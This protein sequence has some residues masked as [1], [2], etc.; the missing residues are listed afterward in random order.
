MDCVSL[1]EETNEVEQ[2]ETTEK[3]ATTDQ[4]KQEK[5]VK[6]RK[7]NQF[8]KAFLRRERV[9]ALYSAGFK[10]ARIHEILK[11][12]AEV[13][14]KLRPGMQMT[15][16]SLVTIHKDINYLKEHYALSADSVVEAK[17]SLLAMNREVLVKLY[18]SFMADGRLLT[19]DRFFRASKELAELLGVTDTAKALDLDLNVHLISDDEADTN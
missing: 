17:E 8:S 18:H 4:E 10:A 3:P 11:N 7:P 12:E 6:K 2:V 1:M 9:W 16:V 14:N 13:N 5:A 15:A 19:A